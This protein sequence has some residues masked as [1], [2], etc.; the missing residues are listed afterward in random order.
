MTINNTASGDISVNIFKDQTD[1]C[2]SI[3]KDT[4]GSFIGKSISKTESIT[5]NTLHSCQYF[6]DDTHTLSLTHDYTRIDTKIKGHE[7]L[8]RKVTSDNSIPMRNYVVI[9]ANGLINEIYLVFSDTEFVSINRPN[10]KLISE[11]EIISFAQKLADFF[12]NGE[13]DVQHAKK[14]SG[15]IPALAEE[16]VIRNFF[17]L[18][19]ERNIPDA[20]SMMSTALAGDD[21]TKKAWGVQFNDIKAI[22]VLNIEPSLPESWTENSH[23]YK[24]TLEAYVSSDAAD[25]PIPY[26]GWGDNPNFRWVEIIKKGNLWK[27]NS[28]A[29][30]P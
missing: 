11:G 17:S 3:N 6:L 26:Y 15:S 25:A 13:P 1:L 14:S 9:Q 2:I 16:D 24:V 4:V 12:M 20:I 10:G 7:L 27:I 19:H 28:L 21:S 29:T 30:G 22:S 5:D 8:E 18:I 23:T